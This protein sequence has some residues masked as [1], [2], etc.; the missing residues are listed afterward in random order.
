[1]DEEYFE[2]DDFDYKLDKENYYKMLQLLSLY[3][4]FN[5]K[6]NKNLLIGLRKHF[7]ENNNF[8]ENQ[9]RAIHNVMKYF[10][11]NKFFKIEEEASGI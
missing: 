10:N 9:K 3:S 2:A 7:M 4:I 11:V 6:V 1:M 5:N 8:T